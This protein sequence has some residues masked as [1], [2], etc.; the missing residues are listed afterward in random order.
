MFPSFQLLFYNVWLSLRGL[1]FVLIYCDSQVAKDGSQ[2][3]G[4]VSD[5]CQI[6]L[7]SNPPHTFPGTVSVKQ[8][9]VTSSGRWNMNRSDTYQFLLEEVNFPRFIPQGLPFSE[10]VTKTVCG[11]T[12][13]CYME[14]GSACVWVLLMQVGPVWWERIN[15]CYVKPL[16]YCGV[17]WSIS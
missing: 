17:Y 9:H 13:S 12:C 4:R 14:S 11:T 6:F 5:V 1:G 2:P 16:T 8:A 3:C 7:L 10:A 15:L